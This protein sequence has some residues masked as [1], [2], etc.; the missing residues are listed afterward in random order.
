[1]IDCCTIGNQTG[2][3]KLMLLTLHIRGST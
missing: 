1:M 3:R 2:R